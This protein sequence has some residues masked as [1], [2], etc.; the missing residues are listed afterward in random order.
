MPTAPTCSMRERPFSMA[1][2]F[3]QLQPSAK[4]GA[5][6]LQCE[7]ETDAVAW[8]GR[9]LVRVG[10]VPEAGRGIARN[11]QTTTANSRA[12]RRASSHRTPA[13]RSAGGNK[14]VFMVHIPL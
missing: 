4:V 14:R 2:N 13:A 9:L 6:A 11:R 5:A 8:P 1:K 10:G 7:T 3:P 12:R